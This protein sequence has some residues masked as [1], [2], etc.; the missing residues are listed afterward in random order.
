M[1]LLCPQALQQTFVV[2]THNVDDNPTIPMGCSHICGNSPQHH[3]SG[4]TGFT[5]EELSAVLPGQRQRSPRV[6]RPPGAHVVPARRALL[7]ACPPA[8]CPKTLVVVGCL[9]RSNIVTR[10]R[11][12][13]KYP[14]LATPC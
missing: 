11:A 10:T 12:I 4:Q 5:V 6:L 9:I 2:Q 7:A 14:P 8:Q 13:C 1:P 3:S